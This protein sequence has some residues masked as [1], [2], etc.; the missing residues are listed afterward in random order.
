M[1]IKKNFGY[2]LILT[3]CNYI[4]PLLTYP[5]ISRVLG[6]INIGACNFVDSIVNYFVLFSM[7]GVG[8]YGVREIARCRDDISRRNKVF[9]NLFFVNIL[10]T[11]LSVL[12]LLISTYCI[13]QLYAYQKFLGIGIL[14]IVFNLF[15]IEWFFQGIEQFKYITIRS[16]FVRIVYVIAIFLFV[17]SE[18]DT[19]S[20]YLL[21]SLMIVVNACFNWLYSRK[22]RR[23]D[24]NSI[25]IKTYLVPILVFGYYRILTSMYTTFNTTFLGFSSGD[26]EVGYFTTATKLYAIIMSVF[27]A[28]TTVM[29]PRVSI[30]I[31][32]K[33]ITALMRISNQTFEGL[34][35][36]ACPII[37]FCV[38][39]APQIIF[40]ISGSGYEGAI[41]PFR[42]VIAL[43]LIIGMEQIV[44]QQFL[45]ALKSNKP[46]LIVS[47]IGAIIGVACNIV[48]TPKLG[49]VGSAIAWTISEISV[50]FVG[51]MM[52]KK[53]IGFSFENKI[54]IRTI[55]CAFIYV[56]TCV[57]LHLFMPIWFAFISSF[58]IC[59][60][61]FLFLF[62]NVY[63]D[64]IV[65]SMIL[66]FKERI[67]TFIF[68]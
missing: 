16:V 7:M 43:L 60:L 37:I 22:F 19:L 58:V 55:L 40:L 13:P 51:I 15:L 39:Y 63:K 24:L 47:T 4:F 6:V 28:F 46:I 27:T 14:K 41:I 10:L 17:K 33:E 54:L 49:A 26:I 56:T 45:M 52:M 67:H 34:F 50:L 1:S 62:T 5:Y 38:V 12:I 59:V 20:Y 35:S 48:L 30:M 8:S 3:T 57:L 32:K 36:V 68:K 65:C 53:H 42:I 2:N 25:S 29:I 66:S 23:F 44:I 61:I 9:T 11:V 64:T 18:E 21:T 31:E